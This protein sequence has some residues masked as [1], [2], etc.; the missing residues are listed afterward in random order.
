MKYNQIDT[1]EIKSF[2]GLSNLEILYVYIEWN[3]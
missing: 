3:N 2:E 1:V